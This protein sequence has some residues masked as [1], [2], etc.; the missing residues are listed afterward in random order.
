M[1]A[2]SVSLLVVQVAAAG[3]RASAPYYGPVVDVHFHAFHRDSF[4]VRVA[5][6]E[7]FHAVRALVSGLDSGVTDWVAR[8]QGRLLRGLLLPCVPKL[9]G[10]KACY[11]SRTFAP[12][13]EWV[14]AE[15]AAGRI[16]ALGEVVAIYGGLSPAD[17]VLEPYFALAE[18]AVVPVGI[19]MGIGPPNTP[20]DC[21]AQFRTYLGRPHLLEDV[22]VRHPRFRAF[23]SH[24]GYPYGDEMV[25]L[26]SV[27]PNLYVDIAAIAMP[28]FVPRPGVLRLP[29]TLG[30]SGL[31]QS[32]HVWLRL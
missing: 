25:A 31:C 19:H 22:L 32:D 23:V 2:L 12:P 4:A 18:Q 16:V 1:S 24:A 26:L 28:A 7:R 11:P 20:F 27:Y 3:A 8:G 9:L 14:R 17:S 29:S 13:V 6:L 10:L 5:E 21:C 30:L 15:L